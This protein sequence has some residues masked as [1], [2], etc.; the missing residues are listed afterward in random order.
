MKFFNYSE[1]LVNNWAWLDDGLSV[2]L[3]AESCL[4][5]YISL[6]LK[7]KVFILVDFMS[8]SKQGSRPEHCNNCMKS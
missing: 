2:L 7:E 4:H 5:G 3:I 6:A 1:L 8:L